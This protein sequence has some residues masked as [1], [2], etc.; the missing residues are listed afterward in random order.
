MNVIQKSEAIKNGLRKGFQDGS[1]KM[2][3][4]RCYGYEV[5]SDGELVVNPDEARVVC[6]IF[7]QYLAGN[8]LGKIAAGL[9][10][11]GIPSPTGRSKWNREAI[12]KLLSNEKYTGRVLLQKTVS[13]GAVQIEN[14]GLMERYLYTGS[15]EAIISDEMFM[16]VQREKLSRSKEP[17]N[18]VVMKL[19]F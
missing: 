9:E 11:Q 1:S 13:T 4:R 14:D 12:D 19:S 18:H 17:Q 6:W 8:S 16:A 5:G 2:A 10:R 15:H 7:E 3:K